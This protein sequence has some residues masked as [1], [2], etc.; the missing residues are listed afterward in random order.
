MKNLI[1]GLAEVLKVAD[2]KILLAKDG[3]NVTMTV[4]P[5]AKGDTELPSLNFSGNIDSIP[6]DDDMTKLLVEKLTRQIPFISNI[7][8]FEEQMKKAEAQKKEELQKKNSSKSSK[9]SKSAPTIDKDDDDDDD[10]EDD[11]AKETK[12]EEKAPVTQSSLF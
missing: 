3:D 7:N 4:T 12:S 9:T 5:K 6:N 11:N 1:I 8:S 2:V 10:N